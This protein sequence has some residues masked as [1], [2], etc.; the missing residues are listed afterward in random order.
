MCTA[1]ITENGDWIRIYPIP[2]R[3]MDEY[4]KFKKYTWIEAD[5]HNDTSDMRPESH[6]INTS[7]IKIVEN[8]PT[9]RDWGRRRQIILQNSKVHTNLNFVIEEARANKMSLCTFKPTEYLDVI[10]EKNQKL[11]PT[12]EEQ[13]AFQNA[14]RTLFPTTS[15]E[16]EFTGMPHIPYKF[17]IQFKDDSGTISKLSV[18]DW[19]I[20]QL[21][22]TCKAKDNENIA[23]KKVI[24]K[25][26]KFTKENDLHLFLGTMKQMHVRRS[27]N[28][29]TIIGLFYPPKVISYQPTLF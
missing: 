29:Y 21:Y 7:S 12:K 25:L 20:S 13:K 3:T 23:V 1:G 16:V 17:K 22:L 18:I 8:I 15:C 28:P 10:V 24:E 26:L 11:E 27:K 6:K 4:S 14:N 19:E 9:N 2:F 5:I